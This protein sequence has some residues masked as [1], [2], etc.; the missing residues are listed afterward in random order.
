MEEEIKRVSKDIQGKLLE[1]D[2]VKGSKDLPDPEDLLARREIRNQGW[3]SVR[4]VW[5]EGGQIDQMFLQ[6]FPEQTNLADAY[7]ISVRYADDTADILHRDAKE[8]AVTQT[9]KT[10]ISNLETECQE[11]ENRRDTMA[12]LQQEIMA[13]WQAL[14]QP[15]E[16]QLCRLLK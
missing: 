10:Q 11:I 6:H 7:E 1:L 3:R 12:L 8:I 4:S 5:L 9:L 16:S 15:S 14:W 2:N 13:Q